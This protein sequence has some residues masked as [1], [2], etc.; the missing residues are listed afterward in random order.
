MAD[1]LRLYRGENGIALA[2]AT[3]GELAARAVPTSPANYE[4]WVAYLSG[5]YPDLNSEI[6]ARL[7]RGEAFTDELNEDL[8]ERYFAQN[9]LSVRMVEASA[10][11]ARELA[12]VVASLRNAGSLAG[13]YS[14]ALQAAAR[15]M[16]RGADPEAFCSIVARLATA[17]RV[18]AEHNLKLEQQMEA[19][20]RQVEVLQTTLQHVRTEALTDGLTGLANR[21]HFDETLRSCIANEDAAPAGLCLMLCD[22]DHFKRVN[23][24]WGHQVG[25]QVLRYVATILGAQADRDCLA[26]RYG[27]EEFA[28]I[29]PGTDRI[30]A[31]AT[32]ERIRLAVKAKRLSRRSTGEMLGSVTVSLGVAG[33]RPGEPAAAL[34]ARAD[35]CL[36][37]SKRTGRDR[38]TMDAGLDQASA[39]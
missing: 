2:R 34:L 38:C 3:I 22:I 32:A 30:T 10:G 8:Y 26:A 17:T 21:R 39:A 16:E 1:K 29:M 35:A 7:A 18:M 23:D 12:D 9:R 37:Q 5:T 28:V 13:D 14:G 20:S 15:D 24:Q 19:S 6:D 11:I 31:E 4:V 27:G 25:D 36:Y 33:Y